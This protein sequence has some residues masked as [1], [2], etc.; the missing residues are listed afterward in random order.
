MPMYKAV[1]KDHVTSALILL[2][3][4]SQSLALARQHVY[5]DLHVVDRRID[6]LKRNTPS[7]QVF[8]SREISSR[9]KRRQRKQLTCFD[10]Y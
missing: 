8:S 9:I 4:A 2:G 6:S 1:V 5:D 10:G 7:M 3:S